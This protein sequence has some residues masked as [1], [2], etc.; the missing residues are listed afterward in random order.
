MLGLEKGRGPDPC[1]YKRRAS[2][3][4]GEIRDNS[5]YFMTGS[6]PK[7]AC[8]RSKLSWINEHDLSPWTLCIKISYIFYA[9]LLFHLKRSP[10]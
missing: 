8:K 2:A 5:L 7:I 4:S 1:R 6:L 3:I 9:L 10:A